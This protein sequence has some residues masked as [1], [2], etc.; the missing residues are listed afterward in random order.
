MA[1][2]SQRPQGPARLAPGAGAPLL[3]AA[4]M[5]G[6]VGCAPRQPKPE[7]GT[8]PTQQ[9]ARPPNTPVPPE[10]NAEVSRALVAAADL[11]NRGENDLACEQ[12]ANAERWQRS[13]SAA[14]PSELE[15]FR[16]ACQTP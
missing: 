12:V 6:L 10:A 16:Q 13:A 5:L 1:E 8:T 2:C 7:P 4:L 3:L 9:P 15:R 14:A 11:F